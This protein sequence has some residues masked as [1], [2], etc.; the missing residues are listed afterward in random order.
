MRKAA[1]LLLS[2]GLLA[3]ACVAGGDNIVAVDATSSTVTT[4]PEITTS[5]TPTGEG[6]GEVV[7]TTTSS[8]TTTLPPRPTGVVTADTLFRPWGTVEGL[9]MFRGNPTRTFFG[10]GPLPDTAP[11][12]LWRYPESAMSGL[13]PV[14]SE[15]KWWTG[16][17]WTGQPLVLERED[18]I[19]ELIFGAYDKQIH[20]L[21]ASS[22][23]QVRPPFH[24]GD[25]I[26]G[27]L[28]LDPDGYPLL[29]G[30][31][32]DPRFRILALDGDEVREVWSI[33][34]KSVEGM[35]ND[36]WD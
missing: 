36:D 20:V 18:G 4:L 6:N 29:Y 13:S 2:L 33:H 35:C 17:G 5:T 1:F 31:S 10:T 14:G 30:G 27:T 7:D 15:E 16:T 34:A 9:T 12:R 21:D 32:R 28:T 19:T 24:M 3:S 8:T 23:E 22:G 25:I 11:D 26:K